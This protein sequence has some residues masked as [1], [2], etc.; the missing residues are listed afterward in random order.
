MSRNDDR[1]LRAQDAITTLQQYALLSAQGE[2]FTHFFPRNAND[3]RLL[4]R[5]SSASSKMEEKL[6][7][8]MEKL[9]QVEIMEQYAWEDQEFEPL[10]EIPFHPWFPHD[11]EAIYEY[12]DQLPEAERLAALLSW[13]PYPDQL[14]EQIAEAFSLNVSPDPI[15]IPSDLQPIISSFDA[16]K[17]PIKFFAD[18]LRIVNRATG[19]Y[20]F[21]GLCMCG[22]GCGCGIP[23]NVADINTVASQLK[24][25]K[26]ISKRTSQISSWIRKDPNANIPVLLNLFSPL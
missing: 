23:W 7:K 2:V 8:A 14:E 17:V 18:S 12:A 25:A 22:G 10:Q 16:Q 6:I 9:F 15:N 19:N 13:N 20:W 5:G 1:V 26:A 21:D 11:D 24:K 4:N 3:A